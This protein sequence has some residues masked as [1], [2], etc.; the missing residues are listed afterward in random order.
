MAVERFVAIGDSF[1][2]GLEDIA[3]D[4]TPRG[5]ADLVATRLAKEVP[6]LQYAN[7]AV[8]G[9]KLRGI[10]DEQAP[11][12]V[13]LA[14]DLI[15]VGAGGN[16]I[17][18]W[19]ADVEEL[20]RIF[21]GML[22]EL[23]ATGAT[24]LAFCGFDP[25]RRIPLTGV[26]G[27]RAEV[28]NAHIRASVA[29]HGARLVDLWSLPRIYEDRMWAPDRLHLST[30][31]HR[32]VA[33][34]VLTELGIPQVDLQPDLASSTGPGAAENLRWFVADVLPWAY[35]RLRGQSSGDGRDPKYPDY[36]DWGG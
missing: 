20:G 36:V 28:Y 22:A 35:R 15:T 7:L 13:A 29:A 2:E 9:R 19:S 32:L 12:A 8:R 24:V 10:A 21:D 14:P 6:R 34:A 17:I 18:R 11:A 31:G 23:T 16:D 3:P 4:G 25:R 1:T 30:D 33:A 26:P 5:W 27:Q